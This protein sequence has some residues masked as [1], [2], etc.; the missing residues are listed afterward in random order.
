MQNQEEDFTVDCILI[1][2]I[3][4]LFIKGSQ[5]TTSPRHKETLNVFHWRFRLASLIISGEVFHDKNFQYENFQ[6]GR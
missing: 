1:L 5:I 3:N 4:Y 6:L 2:H